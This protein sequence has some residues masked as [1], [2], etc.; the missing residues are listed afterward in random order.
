MHGSGA[1]RILRGMGTGVPRLPNT[2]V[3]G[4]PESGCGPEGG[5]RVVIAWDGAA[6]RARLGRGGRAQARGKFGV[7]WEVGV[8]LTNLVRAAAVNHMTA[9]LHRSF[10]QD[11]AL[12]MTRIEGSW[13]GKS[14]R[15]GE[16]EELR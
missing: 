10:A 6:L 4:H 13:S 5:I 3:M 16:I 12:R 9:E 11:D 2:R 8:M 7:Q 14:L 15:D 1:V